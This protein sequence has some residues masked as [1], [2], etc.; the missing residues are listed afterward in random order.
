LTICRQ[1]LCGKKARGN[2]SFGAKQFA[3]DFFTSRPSANLAGK[4]RRT[5][6]FTVKRCVAVGA[7]RLFY[8]E[9]NMFQEVM[10][11]KIFKSKNAVYYFRQFVVEVNE[12]QF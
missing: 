10:E 3:E 2:Q 1:C 7:S 5:R 11:N 8:L 9:Q 4:K 6:K 12:K